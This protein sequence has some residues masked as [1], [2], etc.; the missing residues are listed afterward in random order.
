[1]PPLLG[2]IYSGDERPST[3]RTPLAR[4]IIPWLLSVHGDAV[5]L[6]L[7]TGTDPSLED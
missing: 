1:V 6:I 4:K 3:G 2:R 7:E 5:R